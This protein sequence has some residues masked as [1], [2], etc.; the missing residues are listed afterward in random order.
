MGRVQ[1]PRLHRSI[2]GGTEGNVVVAPNAI[3]L[4]QWQYFAVTMDAKGNVTLYKNGAVIATG[5][6]TCRGPGIVRRGQ[7]PGQEQLRATLLVRWRA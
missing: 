2:Q 5:T 4:N 6:T 3:A 7:L 1:Q